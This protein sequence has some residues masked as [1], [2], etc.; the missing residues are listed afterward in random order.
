ML[1]LDEVPFAINA[2]TRTISNP[3]ITIVQNDQNSEVIL[4][5]ID[6]YFDYKDLDRAFIYVQWTLPDGVTEGATQVEMKDLSIPGKIRFGWPLDNEITSQPGNVKF[7]VRFWNIG[8][9]K[10]DNGIE[11]DAVVYSLNTLTSTLYINAALQPELNDGAQVNAPINDGYFKR[12]IINSQLTGEGVAVPLNPRFD[13]PG[14]N[15]NKYESLAAVLDEITGEPTYDADGNPIETLTLKAQAITTDTGVV[16]YEWWYKPA[17][18][19]EDGLFNSQTWY[20]F[21]D[22]EDEDGNPVPGFKKYG[23]SVNNE[24]YEAVDISNGFAIGEKYF[25]LKDGEYVA[26][27]GSEVSELYE[28]YTTYTVPADANVHV[29]G[30]YKV[31]ATNTINPNT[32]T[33]VSSRE[34]EL[35]SP[36]P[37]TFAHN[38][39]LPARAIFEETTDGNIK[40]MDLT[41]NVVADDSIAA[42]RTFSWNKHIV[43]DSTIDN[44]EVTTSNVL[45][46]A[47]PGWYNVDIDSKLNRETKS[48]TS[49]KCKVTA[50]PKIPTMSYNAEAL[51]LMEANNK[52]LPYYT[53][54]T[55]TL[56]VI[57]GS[58]VPEGFESYSA[59]LFSEKI[60]YLWGVQKDDGAFR[61]LNNDDVAS[62]LI[63]GELGK[64][65]LTVNSP[66]N[67]GYTFYCIIR[68]TLNG[69]STECS[70]DEALA[71]YVV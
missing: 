42:K 2:N 46:I 11:K 16:E 25:M 14:L 40:A 34:C 66:G 61:Y 22:T 35:V 57:L 21:N 67:D 51:A 28:K 31:Q 9:V 38:G 15:L 64:P 32:S 70:R 37:V 52:E 39:N 27:D 20:P 17:E 53:T 69:I 63:T 3:K 41:V 23:G 47:T 18:D 50:K 8:R 68:N 12:A 24:V 71:F 4:F 26:Y 56:E 36:D 33:A 1:P 43:N 5:T 19:S 58:V 44:T 45:T 13:E 49:A 7:S 48:A 29:T 55:A 10:D 60:E 6:R 30:Q 54:D 62:G 59:E 65:T